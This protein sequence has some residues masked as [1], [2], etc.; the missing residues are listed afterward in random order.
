MV[1]G[2][3]EV[4]AEASLGVMEEDF[5]DLLLVWTDMMVA[6]RITVGERNHLL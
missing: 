5:L 6:A 4:R 1:K 3:S 2:L